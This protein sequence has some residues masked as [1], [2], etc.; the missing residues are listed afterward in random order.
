MSKVVRPRIPS[1]VLLGCIAP[2][3]LCASTLAVVYLWF[4]QPWLPYTEPAIQQALE[5]HYADQS[6]RLRSFLENDTD[7]K[8]AIVDLIMNGEKFVPRYIL[9][10]KVDNRWQW[11]Y[12]VDNGG[13]WPTVTCHNADAAVSS[14]AVR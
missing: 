11:I 14:T 8:V 1:I 3:M 2:I 12:E 10:Q 7:C 9:L 13:L 4:N 6:F 5:D